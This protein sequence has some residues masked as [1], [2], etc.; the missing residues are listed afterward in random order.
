M[1]N[2]IK[3]DCPKSEIGEWAFCFGLG[4]IFVWIFRLLC[5]PFN[6]DSWILRFA[7]GL[8]V[9]FL[10]ACVFLCGLM[11]IKT[12]D[13]PPILLLIPAGIYGVVAVLSCINKAIQ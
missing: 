7:G 12:D 5:M 6:N 1:D 11:S 2:E 13:F 4:V 10:L 8:S 3:C 9:F